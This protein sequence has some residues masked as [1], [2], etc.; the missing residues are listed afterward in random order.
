MGDPLAHH[1]F[2]KRRSGRPVTYPW[3]EWADGRAWRLRTGED[4]RG[5]VSSFRVLVHKT[6]KNLGLRAVTEIEDE[7]TIIVQFY[8][9]ESA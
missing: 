8:E 9:D 6:A 5:K 2:S 3:H 1:D 7:G 4:F